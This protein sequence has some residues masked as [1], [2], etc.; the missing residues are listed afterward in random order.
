MMHCF[1][2]ALPTICFAEITLAAILHFYVY[3]FGCVE[4]IRGICWTISAHALVLDGLSWKALGHSTYGH[5]LE[6][7]KA[8]SHAFI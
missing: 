1:V 5:G 6:M 3:S 8:I 4:S 7:E 2:I